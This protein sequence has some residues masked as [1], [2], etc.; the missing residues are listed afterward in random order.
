M[1]A[2]NVQCIQTIN[3]KEVL[4][5]RMCVAFLRGK[6]VYKRKVGPIVMSACVGVLDGQVWMRRKLV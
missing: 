6:K 1:K 2:C 5:V 3:R 4:F